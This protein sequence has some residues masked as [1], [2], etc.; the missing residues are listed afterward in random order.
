MIAELNITHIEPRISP[1]PISEPDWLLTT[2]DGDHIVDSMR[3]G[4]AN[5]AEYGIERV[6]GWVT[7]DQERYADWQRDAW[8]FVDLRLV[9]VVE[10]STDGR[11]IGTLEIDGPAL[12]GIE[13]DAGD[14]YMVSVVGELFEEFKPDLAGFGFDDGDSI[15]PTEIVCE[16]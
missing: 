2:I 14:E 10:V 16:Q 6:Q 1:D 5:I 3:Y 9:A 8:H 15:V 7:D 13:S 11:R 4:D 12:G